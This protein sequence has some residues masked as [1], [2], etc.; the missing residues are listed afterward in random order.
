MF[1]FYFVYLRA[2]N[3]SSTELDIDL[4]PP[5]MIIFFILVLAFIYSPLYT[6]LDI[7]KYHTL[8]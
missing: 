1:I 7:H 3:A 6:L 8:F 2:F 4:S 5:T